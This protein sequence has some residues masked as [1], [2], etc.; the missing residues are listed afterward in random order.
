MSFDLNKIINKSRAIDLSGINWSK[1]KNPPLSTAEIRCI[2]YMIDVESY[3]IAYL[4]DLLNTKAIMDAEIADFLPCWAYEESF[5]SRAL[6]RILK[7]AGVELDPSRLRSFQRGKRL[8]EAIKDFLSMVISRFSQDFIAA[9]MTWGAIQ[10]LTT[11]TGYSNLARKSRNEVMIEVVQRIM[12]D[13]SRHFGFYF[14]KAKERLLRSRNARWLTSFLV[15]KF[16]TPVGAGIEPDPEVTF[17]TAYVFGDP[18][19]RKAAQSIDKTIA[20]LPGLEWFKGLEEFVERSCQRLI[21]QSPWQE[22]TEQHSSM[23]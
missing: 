2:T 23:L 15:K 18:E 4:R 10:E 19:G 22:F 3:T 8:Q 9:Y 5:H 12:I 16:W 1:A 13:E 14:H 6:E 7:E 21:A 20:R 17:I 11:L